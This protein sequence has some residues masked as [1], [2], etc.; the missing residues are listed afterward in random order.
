MPVNYTDDIFEEI[1]LQDDIQCKYTGGTVEHIFVGEELSDIE[2]EI[3]SEE[4]FENNRLPIS[5][6]HNI[7]FCPTHGYIAGKH[8]HCPKCAIEQPCEFTLELWDI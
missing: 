2:S 8:F 5:L 6:L 1:K 7:F 4:I 3:I